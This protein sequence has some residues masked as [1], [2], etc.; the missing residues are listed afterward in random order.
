MHCLIDFRFLS[1]P[2]ARGG[3]SCLACLFFVHLQSSPR[4]WGCFL[5]IVS[6]TNNNQVFPT[7]VGVFPQHQTSIFVCAESSPRSWGCFSFQRCV[8]ALLASLPH[9]RGGVSSVTLRSQGRGRS[10]PRSWGC[11][12]KRLVWFQTVDVFPTLVGVFL[13]KACHVLSLSCLPHARG[14]VSSCCNLS[15]RLTLSSPRSWG[16]FYS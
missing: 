9:A 8:G 3:V 6:A 15:C 4:S 11:F 10:S 16:C 14:G 12:C 5:Y 1:L 2:H 7:L 13:F